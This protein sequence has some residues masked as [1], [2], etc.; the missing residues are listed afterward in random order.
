MSRCSSAELGGLIQAGEAGD[1]RAVRGRN[2]FEP[3]R[4]TME[5]RQR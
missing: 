5:W 1:G 2:R 3:D 4:V